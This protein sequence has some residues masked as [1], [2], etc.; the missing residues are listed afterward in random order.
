M[1]GQAWLPT[2]SCQGISWESF[3]RRSES[4]EI[5]SVE[6]QTLY[7][8]WNIFRIYLENLFQEDLN[9]NLRLKYFQW[10][11][12][13]DT[14][15]FVWI[16][17]EISILIFHQEELKRIFVEGQRWYPSSWGENSSTEFFKKIWKEIFGG[18]SNM[19]TATS[20]S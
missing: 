14:Q 16:Y 1:E 12:K 11:V 18:R 5:C 10:K 7:P 15:L 4:I 17:L 20:T 3:S 19:I 8:S 13:H 6:G 9:R 2:S